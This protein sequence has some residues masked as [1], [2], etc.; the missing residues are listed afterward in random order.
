MLSL[1]IVYYEIYTHIYRFL[2]IVPGDY[3]AHLDATGKRVDLDQRPELTRG[4]VEFVA[5]TEYM[6]RPPMPPSYFFLI[7]VSVSA[8]RSGMIEVSTCNC[9]LQF[10]FLCSMVH[11]QSYQ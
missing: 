10:F 1:F 9:L 3:F 6:I 7:D 4:S 2:C 11:A 5:P 8:V